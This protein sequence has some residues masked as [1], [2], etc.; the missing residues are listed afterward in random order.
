M[1]YHLAHALTDEL[2]SVGAYA[3][4]LADGRAHLRLRCPEAAVLLLQVLG[5][6][7]QLILPLLDLHADVALELAMVPIQESARAAQGLGAAPAVDAADTEGWPDVGDSC[8]FSLNIL[9]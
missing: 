8:F 7:V 3:A 5:H 1:R 9:Y 2:L 4:Q 6:G